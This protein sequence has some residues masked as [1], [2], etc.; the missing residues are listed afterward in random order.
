MPIAPEFSSYLKGRNSISFQCQFN[1]FSFSTNVAWMRI[2]QRSGGQVR[3]VNDL[4][5]PDVHVFLQVWQCCFCQAS[6]L[7]HTCPFPTW[8]SL[9]KTSHVRVSKQDSQQRRCRKCH[10]ITINSR[11]LWIDIGFFLPSFDVNT[12]R[13]HWDPIRPCLEVVWMHAC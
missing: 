2:S 11:I 10:L 7:A 8:I 1:E 4:F 9:L 13:T 6:L 12:I 5:I 3:C